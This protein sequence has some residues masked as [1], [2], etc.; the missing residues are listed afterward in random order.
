MHIS[1]EQ[2]EGPRQVTCQEQL[3]P[4]PVCVALLLLLLLLLG[5]SPNER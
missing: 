3:A 1:M 2:A 4:L 5:N